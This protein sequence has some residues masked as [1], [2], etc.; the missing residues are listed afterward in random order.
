M[1]N[2]STQE[3]VPIAGIKD[4][5]VILKNGQY[6]LIL[7]VGA[8]NFDLKSE[9][10]QNSLVFQYQSFLNS[11]HFPI[12]IAIQSKK[13]DLTPY[14]NTIST[15]AENQ[16]NELLKLQTTD[17]VDFVR[18]LIGVANIMKK[19]FYV[20]VG[21]QPLA[22][23]KSG[24]L[25]K[26]FPKNNEISKVKVSDTEFTHHAKELRQHAQTVASGLAGMGLHAK[27]VSTQEA[28]ELFYKIFNPEISGKERMTEAKNISSSYITSAANSP[29]SET[30]KLDS[31]A[32]EA[33]SI[34]GP[35]I[36]NTTQVQETQKQQANEASR[37]SREAA[38][39]ASVATDEKASETSTTSQTQTPTQNQPTTPAQ[40]PVSPSPQSENPNQPS[41]LPRIEKPVTPKEPDEAATPVQS[42]DLNKKFS[43]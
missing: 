2:A 39:A 30:Q 10:E 13:L 12:Q 18:Q 20:V 28:I 43:D 11:L 24:L 6:R 40:Y 23:A 22:S 26:I 7:S 9:Q 4:G 34:G 41:N 1:S 38:P 3:N 19:S 37:A 5:I 17:Y 42:P 16:Q 31:Q 15:L 14:L 32:V 21:Y 35:T 25:G 33:T 36:D 8:I 27:Q 29:T